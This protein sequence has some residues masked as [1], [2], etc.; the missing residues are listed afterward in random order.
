M[1]CVVLSRQSNDR[2]NRKVSLKLSVPEAKIMSSSL[3]E[4]EEQEEK[5]EDETR[6]EERMKKERMNRCDED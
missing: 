5:E 4:S 3:E 2:G 1:I 6:E